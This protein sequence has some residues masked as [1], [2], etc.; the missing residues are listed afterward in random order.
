MPRAARTEDRPFY[1][2]LG[3]TP[4]EIGKMLNTG[5]SYLQR[6]TG[7]AA[8]YHRLIAGETIDLGGRTW[9]ILTGGGHA[10]EQAML[11]CEAEHLFLSADQVLA[12]ISPNVSVFEI[13]PQADP[14]GIYLASLRAIREAVPDDVRVM[15]C[16]NLPFDGLHERIGQLIRHHE[17]RCELITTACAET[18]LTC[19]ELI[20]ILFKRPLDIHT[21]GFALGEGLAHLNYLVFQNRLRPETRDGV[22]R[23]RTV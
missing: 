16:H 22:V 21:L 23:Y 3:L 8:S 7:I 5:K 12:K 13:E 11:H 9:R 1:Q 20:P 10:P 17:Y 2:A 19:L 14:L 4:A 6:V 15:P 18:A